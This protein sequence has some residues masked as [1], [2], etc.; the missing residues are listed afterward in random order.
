MEALRSLT[1]SDFSQLLSILGNEVIN[2]IYE[3]DC[4]EGGRERPRAASRR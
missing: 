4:P 1:S 2:H 3:A